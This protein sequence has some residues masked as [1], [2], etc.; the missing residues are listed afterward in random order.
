MVVV[1]DGLPADH[2]GV[3]RAWPKSQGLSDRSNEVSGSLGV[4]DAT[5]T[6]I[7]ITMDADTEYYYVADAKRYRRGPVGVVDTGSQTSVAISL[8]RIVNAQ[9]QELIPS[10]LT[11]AEQAQADLID[12]DADFITVDADGVNDEISYNALVYAVEESQSTVEACGSLLNPARIE[13]GR[14]VFPATSDQKWRAKSSLTDSTKVPDLQSTAIF[15]DG[16]EDAEDFVDF[17]NGPLKYKAEA[18]VFATITGTTEENIH[19]YLDDYPDKDAWK[20]DVSAIPT[21]HMPQATFDDRV[22]NVP[23][24][25]KD[26]YKGSGGSSSYSEAN[27]HAH[28]NSYA[29]KDDWK[30]DASALSDGD[31]GLAA[32]K[33]L[34]DTVSGHTD[35][36]D[37]GTNGLANLKTL[38]DTI[39]GHTDIISGHTDI[40]DDGT[41]GLA[42]IRTLVD[43]V[44]T[45]NP[46]VTDI[47]TGM[48]TADF[49]EGSGTRTLLQMVDAILTAVGAIPT[50]NPSAAAIAAEVGS[51]T[52]G[53][54]VTAIKDLTEDST[55][56]LAALKA[57]IDTVDAV[58]DANK[59]LLEDGDSGLVN[60]KALLDTISD[61]ADILDD[62]A[63]GLL[64]LKTLIETVDTVVDANKALLEDGTSG[65]A[66]IKTS[67]DALPA[68][69]DVVTAMQAAD[70]DEGS[71]TRT[72]L[73]VLSALGSAIQAIPTSNPTAAQIATA[74]E[75]G[76]VGSNLTNIKQSIDH[77]TYGLDA[78]RT[79][80]QTVDTVVDSNKATLEDNQHGLSALRTL[81]RTVDTVVDSN[82]ATLESDEHGMRALKTLIETVDT[83]ADANKALLENGTYGLE[84]LKTLIETVDTV[85]D[86]NKATLED[87]DHG[88]AHIIGT[89]DTMDTLL[90]TLP[91]STL[92]RDDVDNVVKDLVVETGG[93]T[94][95]LALR[96][97][98]GVAGA[99]VQSHPNKYDVYSFVTDEYLAS[100]PKFS[101]NSR[102]SG[103]STDDE[104]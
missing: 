20:A 59:A 36:L 85:V 9:G 10:A 96:I 74:I 82:K 18:P 75:D 50:S 33:T 1:F 21:D 57:L 99:R 13:A 42:A 43:A 54:E 98:L 15:K 29:D 66:A 53:T 44:P 61:Y 93:I 103:A 92:S 81:I 47:V 40:L 5:N 51:S 2:Q 69:T 22:A 56:G 58:A 14:I 24:D 16:S 37:D 63:A 34:L 8:E 94:L 28:L 77:G 27:L 7:A 45:D 25:T 78:L 6:S 91:T 73:Q 100:I 31:H 83:V 12:W 55:H 41:N 70:F 97:L 95:K 30:A 89:I 86:T 19:S 49:E 38:L 26:M 87:T 88:L 46:S 68:T 39:S 102:P 17:S 65:L 62:N 60:L 3:V 80:I 32:L 101:R 48:Q 11:T 104:G 84:Q 71:G 90:K 23:S 64:A 52:I 79:L 76:A 72:L 67:V 35:I 4:D